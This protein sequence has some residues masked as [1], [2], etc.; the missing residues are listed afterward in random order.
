MRAPWVKPGFTI[1]YSDRM[2]P[3]GYE[4]CRRKVFKDFPRA[5]QFAL[6]LSETHHHPVVMA[7][8]EQGAPPQVLDLASIRNMI[9]SVPGG[10]AKDGSAQGVFARM[11]WLRRM[12]SAMGR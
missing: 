10:G 1:I 11:P 8:K 5:A 4:Y 3:T 7:V 12:A 9:G 2:R 6:S